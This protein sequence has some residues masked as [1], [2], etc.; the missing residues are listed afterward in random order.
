MPVHLQIFPISDS[1]SFMNES[2]SMIVI[3]IEI[4]YYAR[5]PLACSAGILLGQVNVIGLRSFIRLAMF[6]LELEWTV[7]G[8]GQGK[9]ENLLF[10]S[11]T[12]LIFDSRP[13]P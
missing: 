7:G 13:P 12:L 9:G 8:R 1:F 4:Q 3:I 6:D 2:F 10:P 11:P 5:M